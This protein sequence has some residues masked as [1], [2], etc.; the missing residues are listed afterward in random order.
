ML[1]CDIGLAQHNSDR[2]MHKPWWM[3]LL[4]QQILTCPNSAHLYAGQVAPVVQSIGIPSTIDAV[5]LCIV[6]MEFQLCVRLCIEQL[7]GRQKKCCVVS[8]GLLCAQPQIARTPSLSKGAMSRVASCKL[9]VASCELQVICAPRM[10]TV[11]MASLF[12]QTTICTV[13]ARLAW[14][15]QQKSIWLQ[16][17]SK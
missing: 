16:N 14:W 15:Q 6:A 17:S 9:Q 13:S 12:V 3:I 10:C 1:R 2:P 4:L 5:A 11:L 8:G 7:Y